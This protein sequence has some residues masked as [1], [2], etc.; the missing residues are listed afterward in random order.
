MTDKGVAE[1][2]VSPN[3]DIP[4]LPFMYHTAVDAHRAAARHYQQA[5]FPLDLE[6]PTEGME[7][8]EHP[9]PKPFGLY[10]ADGT[11]LPFK[12][13]PQAGQTALR[14][15]LLSLDLLMNGIMSK[16]LSVDE[17]AAWSLE[18]ATVGLKVIHAVSVI[19]QMKGSMQDLFGITIKKEAVLSDLGAVIAKAVCRGCV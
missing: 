13:D 17:Y 9:D 10:Q 11:Q 16:R 1:S 8:E 4:N 12:H 15:L 2:T 18:Y 3:L 6:P 19:G 14:L 7:L 5:F